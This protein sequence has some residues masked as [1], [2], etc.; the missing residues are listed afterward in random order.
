MPRSRSIAVNAALCA[1]LSLAG[2][3]TPVSPESI[4]I[5]ESGLVAQGLRPMT[6]EE[7]KAQYAMRARTAQ[8][9]QRL[10]QGS[11]DGTLR[12]SPDGVVAFKGRYGSATGRWRLDGNRLC[13]T[14]PRPELVGRWGDEHCFRVYRTGENELTWYP[15]EGGVRGRFVD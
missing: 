4:P 5:D 2:C 12:Y 1:L 11:T 8:Y 9:V 14:Y 6:P 13:K 15:P 3:A 10:K 7:L